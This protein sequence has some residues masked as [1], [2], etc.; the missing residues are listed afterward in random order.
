MRYKKR[1][2]GGYR[3]RSFSLFEWRI[4][5]LSGVEH[6]IKGRRSVALIQAKWFSGGVKLKSVMLINKL[7]N[8]PV[9]GLIGGEDGCMR[10]YIYSRS[11]NWIDFFVNK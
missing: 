5:F 8:K 3:R 2:K 6:N 9:L 4:T 10:R 7:N 11:G 1:K